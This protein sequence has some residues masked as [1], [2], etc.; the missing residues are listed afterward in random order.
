MPGR[1]FDMPETVD[2]RMARVGEIGP[3]GV[4]LLQCKGI[5][6]GHVFKLGTKYS[7]AL[8]AGVTDFQSKVSKFPHGLLRHWYNADF[9]NACGPEL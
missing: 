2:L 3:D 4:P 8:S 6:I 5:E 1:D 7:E 9:T